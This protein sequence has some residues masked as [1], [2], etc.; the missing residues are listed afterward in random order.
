M[1]GLKFLNELFQ[2]KLVSF[3]RKQ[4]LSFSFLILIYIYNYILIYFILCFFY[5]PYYCYPYPR[6]VSG[7]RIDWVDFERVPFC[8][9]NKKNVKFLLNIDNL[10]FWYKS[11][12]K[13]F[14]TLFF[15]N[16]FYNFSL[17][18]LPQTLTLLVSGSQI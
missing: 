11:F 1:L 6:S 14:I 2:L 9:I 18:L 8:Q 10:N 12:R 16:L 4:N 7:S 3:F 17:S 15:I 13:S 5:F